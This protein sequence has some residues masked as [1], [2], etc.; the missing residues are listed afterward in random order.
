MYAVPTQLASVKEYRNREV[1][2]YGQVRSCLPGEIRLYRV[3]DLDVEVLVD[4]S[5]LEVPGMDIGEWYRFM[6]EVTGSHNGEIRVEL[7]LLPVPV[8]GYSAPTYAKSMAV[9]DGFMQEIDKLVL[10]ADRTSRN[11]G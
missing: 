4:L 9:R 5:H 7:R 6:G 8:A 2:F 11:P 10:H 3:G 1:K